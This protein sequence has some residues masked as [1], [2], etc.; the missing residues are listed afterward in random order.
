MLFVSHNMTAVQTLCEKAILTTM[1]DERAWPVREI[2]A[3]TASMRRVVVLTGISKRCVARVREMF[4][5]DARAFLTRV[6]VQ[7]TA[8][9][10]ETS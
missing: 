4:V 3:T 2:V 8:Q 7:R 5:S 9:E 1:V 6:V 10:R